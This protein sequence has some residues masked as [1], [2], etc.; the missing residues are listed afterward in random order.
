LFEASKPQAVSDFQSKFTDVD[1]FLV[2]LTETLEER[3][4]YS[5]RSMSSDVLT[6]VLQKIYVLGAVT[7]WCWLVI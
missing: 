4:K 1:S 6:E 7:Q 5:G 2:L 3:V